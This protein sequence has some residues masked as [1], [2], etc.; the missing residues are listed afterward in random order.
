MAAL[1]F[2]YTH[3]SKKIKRAEEGEEAFFLTSVTFI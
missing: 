3:E 1:A 2:T